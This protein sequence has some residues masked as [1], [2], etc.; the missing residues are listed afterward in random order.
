M[1]AARGS[2]AER[3]EGTGFLLSGHGQVC[4]TGRRAGAGADNREKSEW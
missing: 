2:L 3:R 1:P 4:G